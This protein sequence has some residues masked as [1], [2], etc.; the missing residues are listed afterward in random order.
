M[1]ET[2][3]IP[4]RNH[5]CQGHVSCVVQRPT[6]DMFCQ[7]QILVCQDGAG[8]DVASNLIA[9]GAVSCQGKAS[10]KF[11]TYLKMGTPKMLSQ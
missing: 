10:D 4:S 6:S 2:N 7:T 5:V 1:N 8:G 11:L 3:V 9:K